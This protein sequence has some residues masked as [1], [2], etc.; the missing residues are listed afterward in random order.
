MTITVD[1][2]TNDNNTE[3]N[4]TTNNDILDGIELVAN[5][6]PNN[7]TTNTTI[8]QVGTDTDKKKCPP[9]C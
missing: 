4:E 5:V 6:L 2:N 3:N 1:N 8:S 7:S 9:F